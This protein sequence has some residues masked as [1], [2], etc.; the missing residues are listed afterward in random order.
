M[1]QK[2]YKNEYHKAKAKANIHLIDL[3]KYFS[4]IIFHFQGNIF[5]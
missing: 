1:F 5:S 2:G 4:F 3:L